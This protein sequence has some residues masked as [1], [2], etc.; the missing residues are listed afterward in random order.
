MIFSTDNAFA[1][2]LQNGSV[3]FWGNDGQIIPHD[4]QLQL[5]E[6]VQTIF[7]NNYAFVALLKDG[8]FVA[9]GN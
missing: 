8:R 1:A 2:L 5:H 9:W 6:S 4:L 3:L 7:S